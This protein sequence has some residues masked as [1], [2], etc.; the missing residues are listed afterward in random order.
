MISSEKCE[1]IQKTSVVRLLKDKVAGSVMF[2]FTM[3]SV[4]LLI[5]IGGWSDF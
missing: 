1:I 4:L 2:I 3:I 5:L